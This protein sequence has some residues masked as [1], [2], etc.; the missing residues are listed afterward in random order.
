[1]CKNLPSK[2]ILNLGVPGFFQVRGIY[3]INS[4]FSLGFKALW[5]WLLYINLDS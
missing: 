3:V 4:G 2:L 1:M 5:G